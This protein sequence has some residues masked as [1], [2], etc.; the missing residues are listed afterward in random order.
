MDLNEGQRYI[1]PM[2][3][4]VVRGWD[5]AYNIFEYYIHPTADGEL[6]WQSTSFASF[7]SD[8]ALENWKN[9]MHEVSFRK[10]GIISQ[11]LCHVTTE[12]VEL[13]TYKGILE[14]SMFLMELEEKVLESH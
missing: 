1:E 2:K 8:D 7:D 10:R 12:V 3:D 4:E 14:L 11:S 9:R 6:G 13:P 5:H